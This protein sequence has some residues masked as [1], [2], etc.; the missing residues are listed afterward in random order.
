[1][2]NAAWPTVHVKWDN[3]KI[4]FKYGV[5]MWALSI[6]FAVGSSDRIL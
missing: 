4:N 6:W 3:I 1:M 2:E 5:R